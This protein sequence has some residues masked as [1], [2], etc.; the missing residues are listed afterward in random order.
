MRSRET[1]ATRFAGVELFSSNGILLDLNQSRCSNHIG[2]TT[3]ALTNDGQ[4][5]ATVQSSA[6]AQNAEQFSPAG[7]GSA[8]WYDLKGLDAKPRLLDFLVRAMERELVE[9]CGMAHGRP[10]MDTLVLGF[11][12]LLMRGGKPE[13]FG[14]TKLDCHSSRLH[15]ARREEVFIADVSRSR[16]DRSDLEALRSSIDNFMVSERSSFSLQLYVNLLFLSELI[17]RAPDLVA[18]F[19][20]CEKRTIT[21]SSRGNPAS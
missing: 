16:I 1:N 6:S 12:R 17:E 2:I 4:L 13:F 9:E 19:V 14:L 7:S 15:V 3:L 11:C 21:G 18:N 8:D 5:V 20:S 10:E